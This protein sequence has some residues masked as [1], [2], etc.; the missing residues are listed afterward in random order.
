MSYQ[1]RASGLI[2]EANNSTARSLLNKVPNAQ[3]SD[4][5]GDAIIFYS[6]STKKYSSLYNEFF[7]NP[8]SFIDLKEI[9][10]YIRRKKILKLNLNAWKL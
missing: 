6:S 3:G 5:T 10:H 1:L 8:T 2:L 7:I 9:V 4:T